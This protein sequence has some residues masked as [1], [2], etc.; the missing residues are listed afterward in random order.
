VS[1]AV[2][3]DVAA[4]LDRLI[5]QGR[6]LA[7][8]ESLTGGELC[9]L[10]TAPAGASRVVRGG[11]VVYATDSKIDLGGVDPALVA[12]VG[13][14]DP[15]VAEQL[16]TGARK[17]FDSWYGLGVTG[18]AGP[19][20]QDGHPVGEVHIAVATPES[21][22]ARTYDLGSAGDRKAIR[23]AACTA[24]VSLLEQQARG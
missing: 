19:S 14:V 10:L 22:V 18:V 21:V 2:V 12:A 3:D 20:E 24:A 13:P 9:A 23:T 16:A 17:T 7:V 6:T 8:A 11:L 5:G 1:E 4:L 15:V